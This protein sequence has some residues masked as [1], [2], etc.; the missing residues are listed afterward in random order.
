[1]PRQASGIPEPTGRPQHGRRSHTAPRASEPRRPRGGRAGGAVLR[2]VH[3]RLSAQDE[4]AV[5]L[6]TI[7]DFG[8][9]IQGA[10]AKAGVLTAVLGLVVGSLVNEATG[11]RAALFRASYA[12]RVPGAAFVVFLVSLAVAGVALG[13]TQVPRLMT[14][15]GSCR[16]AF[17]AAAHRGPRPPHALHQVPRTRS[18]VVDLHDEAWRQAEVLATIAMRKFR[19]LRI[20]LPSTGLCVAAFVCWLITSTPIT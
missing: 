3:H 15:T 5:A 7:D 14:T 6:H 12:L 4:L 10:D 11:N 1:M 16:L 20:A 13:M 19:H 2:P 8:R 18:S 17:P 9:S